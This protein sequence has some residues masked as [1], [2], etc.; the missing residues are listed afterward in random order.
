MFNYNAFEKRRI[1]RE[2]LSGIKNIIFDLGG[3]IIDIYYNKTIE[4]F[5]KLGF[6]DFDTI[7][8]QIKQTRV[9][10]LLE[11]G[12]LPPQGFRMEL[13]KFRT[14]LTNDQIDAA[15]SAMIGEMP[16]NYIEM[17]S[18]L[19]GKYRT[20]LLSNTNA[21]HIEFF[22]RGLVK[23]F[24]YNPL[25]D[26]FEYLYLSHEMG[27]RKP[28]AEAYE[29]VLRDA[30]INAA[31]TLFIDDLEENIKGAEKVGLHTFQ[32]VD[33]KLSSLFMK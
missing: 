28:D 17:L 2:E 8:T 15:W 16:E 9:F 20:F 10:D 18:S 13:R 33:S 12:K 7:Y 30:G 1:S 6:A 11:T 3:V 31:E 23:K 19:R 32:L 27:F 29:Y 14:H 4:S 21:I 25:P 24:G 5:K 22:I 26:M